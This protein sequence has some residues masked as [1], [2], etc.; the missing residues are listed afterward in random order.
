MPIR[1]TD[2][3]KQ[4]AVTDLSNGMTLEQVAKKHKCSIGSLQQWKKAI[5]TSGRQL[6][7]K[8]ADDSDI[9]SMRKELAELRAWK[10]QYLDQQEELAW[11]SFDVT[12][13][14]P[15]N[16][17]SLLTTIRDTVKHLKRDQHLYDEL[18]TIFF[19]EKNQQQTGQLH[20]SSEYS[21]NGSHNEYHDAIVEEDG[22]QTGNEADPSM[23]A[24]HTR[25][26][27]RL[28]A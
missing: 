18:K 3:Q 9:R 4:A 24:Q 20:L 7:L 26:R 14:T 8:H 15:D 1:F 17:L 16:A 12:S 13:L 10:K 28:G 25:K 23:P 27:K 2:E 6:H 19:P 5:N 11:D 22:P 21:Q